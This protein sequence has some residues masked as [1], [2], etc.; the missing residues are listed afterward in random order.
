[1]VKEAT[2]IAES[3]T[4][5]GSGPARRH[6]KAGW[7]PGVINNEKGQAQS[8]R[9]NL[10]DFEQRL[11][12]HTG[13]NLILDIAVDATAPR[14]VLLR[15]V[16]HDAI[17]GHPLHVDFVE[18]SMTRKM[19]VRISILLRGD[20]FGVVT[21]GGILEQLLREVEVECLPGD[22]VESVELDVSDLHIGK[23][24]L[25]KDLPVSDKLHVLTNLDV[26]VAAVLA[27]K[28][29]EA[30]VAEAVAGEAGAAEPEVITKGKEDE[31]G[32]EA[33]DGK[34][35]KADDKA[36]KGGAKPAKPAKAAK[37]DEKADKGK[38]KK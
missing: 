29:E 4:D 22:M 5:A 36:A 34:A 15:E 38:E 19:R 23:R 24:L 1:M 32:A 8:V 27:P 31:A 37:G 30:P 6:R 35:V 20:P 14:K 7:L 28:E 26:A 2:L 25:V 10:H 33:A 3:R 16:Q 18:V 9:M 11:R 21:E 12:H 13:E 17:S